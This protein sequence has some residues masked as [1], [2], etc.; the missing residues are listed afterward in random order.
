MPGLTSEELRK[1][2]E[3]LSQATRD[4]LISWASANPTTYVWTKA[5]PPKA[6]LVLQQVQRRESILQEGR[7]S[8]RTSLHYI[9]E[10]YDLEVGAMALREQIDGSTDQDLNR[11]LEGLFTHI[12]NEKLQKDREFLRGTLPRKQ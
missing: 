8:F 2:L 7:R 11:V 10:V 3:E 1:Y 6:R 12:R 5:E 4:G 9:L